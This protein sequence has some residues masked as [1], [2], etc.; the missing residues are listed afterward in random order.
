M[1]SLQR[2]TD[3][4]ARAGRELLED[5]AGESALLA[6]DRTAAAMFTSACLAAGRLRAGVAWLR[7]AGFSVRR[8]SRV[9]LT[10]SQ[11]DR[12]W[13]HQAAGFTAERWDVAARMFCAGPAVVAVVTP[14]DEGRS[15]A[16]RLKTLQGPSDPERLAARHLRWSLGA[17]NKIN[18]LVH[19]PDDA[20]ATVRELPI[21]LGET[22]AR[23]AWD[24]VV[25]GGTTPD[26][27]A[28]IAGLGSAPFDD[29]VCFVRSV[30]RLRWRAVLAGE[31]MVGGSAPAELRSALSSE[32]E[33][34]TGQPWGGWRTTRTWSQ[35]FGARRTAGDF[36]RWL[37]PSSV[38]TKAMAEL[39]GVVGADGVHL[40]VL[41]AR[42]AAAGLA[43]TA[44]ELLAL[45]TQ[46]VAQQ[47]ARADARRTAV[48]G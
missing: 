38:V 26:T 37:G 17:V 6:A 25:R 15:A 39:E 33:W 4:D 14:L 2:F 43:P 46:A 18:N 31:A 3:A 27:D 11:V 29:G 40:G 19:V 12:V 41:E 10:K 5:V 16:E 35:R 28:A 42:I 44:W 22:G 13:L 36:A 20:A 9:H 7:D 34:A 45:Q 30:A 32:L 1:I 24:A 8:L 21:L 47:L 48:T 23:A